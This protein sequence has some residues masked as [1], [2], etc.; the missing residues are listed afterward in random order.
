MTFSWPPACT[1]PDQVPR[2][3]AVIVYVI[4]AAMLILVGVSMVSSIDLSKTRRR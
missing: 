3:N 2:E 1:Y 4:L